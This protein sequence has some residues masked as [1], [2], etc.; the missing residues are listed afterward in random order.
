MIVINSSSLSELHWLTIDMCFDKFTK[1]LKCRFM[2]TDSWYAYDTS[3]GKF[4]FKTTVCVFFNPLREEI[5]DE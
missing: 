3:S 5:H 2:K 4:K 1:P